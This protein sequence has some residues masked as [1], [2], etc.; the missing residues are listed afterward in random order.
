MTVFHAN[1]TVNKSFKTRE[2][3]IKEVESLLLNRA[4]NAVLKDLVHTQKN[5]TESSETDVL[6]QF[7]TNTIRGC[8]QTRL[9]CRVMSMEPV[10]EYTEGIN[11]AISKLVK[12]HET[13]TK[14]NTSN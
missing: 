3:K 11:K 13:I 12:I 2:G 1:T 7:I 9:R 14:E 5:E 4:V 10:Q 6:G 8:V